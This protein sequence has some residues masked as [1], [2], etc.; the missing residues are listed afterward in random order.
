L[1]YK[2]PQIRKLHELLSERRTLKYKLKAVQYAE[3]HT[4]K[5]QQK[6]IGWKVFGRR[7]LGGLVGPKVPC[8]IPSASLA[9]LCED[10]LNRVFTPFFSCT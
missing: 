4:G 8:L 10:R 5:R 2:L 3:K 9:K 1:S 7:I 6:R